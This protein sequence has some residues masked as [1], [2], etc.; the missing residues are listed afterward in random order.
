MSPPKNPTLGTFVTASLFLGTLAYNLYTRVASPDYEAI[1]QAIQT[2]GCEL[3][4]HVHDQV[5]TTTRTKAVRRHKYDKD[6]P[7][8]ATLSRKEKGRKGDGLALER[9]EGERSREEALRAL[10]RRVRTKVE[11]RNRQE[12]C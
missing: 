10:E 12:G 2:A 8:T 7:W 1:V 3:Y 4:P 6:D 5:V 11:E 9:V